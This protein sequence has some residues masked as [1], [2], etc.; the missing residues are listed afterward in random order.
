MQ[1]SLKPARLTG[2][3]VVAV[4]GAA[5]LSVG[6]CGSH[7]E[8]APEKSAA[9]SAGSGKDVVRGLVS[10]VSGSTVQVTEAAG[11]ATVEVG[12]SIKVVEDSGAQ[13][14]DVV[15]GN[16]LRVAFARE[17]APAPGGV[18]T[19]GAV[20]VTLPAAGGKC[21]Q[22]KTPA[23]KPLNGTVVSVEGNTITVAFTDANGNPAE[24]QVAVTDKTRYRKDVATN[25]EAIAQNKCI[26][27]RGTKDG[28]GTLQ[29]KAVSLGPSS[30]GKCPQP[31]KKK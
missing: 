24:T 11:T 17:A 7:D 18:S 8:K 20:R 26:V 4:A 9:A 6:A 12:P 14:S 10:S 31:A 2:L 22:P 28:E 13:L 3:A 23:D 21:A 1:L 30:K 27:A 15:A 25:S 16:C 5:V 19:A 29:A